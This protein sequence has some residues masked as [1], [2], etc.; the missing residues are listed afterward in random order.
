LFVKIDADMVIQEVDFFE[1]II[2]ICTQ[3]KYLSW[4]NIDVFDVFVDQFISGINIYRSNVKWI[5]NNDNYFTDRSHILNK[6]S[7]SKVIK[8]PPKK[9]VLHC[10]NPTLEQAFN[11]GL[12]RSIKAYQFERTNRKRN[13]AHGLIVNTLRNNYEKEPRLEFL[14]A[15]Y[16][17]YLAL[18]HRL[19]DQQINKSDSKRHQ[20][21]NECLKKTPTQLEHEIRSDY[22]MRLIFG[23]GKPSYLLLF[24]VFGWIWRRF[25]T[26]DVKLHD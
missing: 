2:H 12:H 9:W 18:K 26:Y 22:M 16:G 3:D 25:E 15:M 4:L 1:Y 23:G 21:L 7:V 6:T 13:S 17:Y 10:P 14:Y 8:N 20:L 5:T 19:T 24:Y 11:F